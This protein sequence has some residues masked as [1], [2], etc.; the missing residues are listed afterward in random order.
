VDVKVRMV[1][2][3]RSSEA[4]ELGH[5][6]RP[7][8][9]FEVTCERGFACESDKIKNTLFHTVF[10]SVAIRSSHVHRWDKPRS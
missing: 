8:D 4:A 7:P 2:T 3:S 9:L 10:I 6:T 5:V 1:G